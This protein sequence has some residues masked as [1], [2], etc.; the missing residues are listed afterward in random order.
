MEHGRE[1][2][3]Q[4]LDRAWVACVSRH[5]CLPVPL[6]HTNL[7]FFAPLNNNNNNN[8]IVREPT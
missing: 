4:H 2:T 6:H 3:H 7:K 1:V 5:P 8:N